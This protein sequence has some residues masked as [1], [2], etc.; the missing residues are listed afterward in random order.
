MDVD[1]MIKMVYKDCLC[2]VVKCGW[3]EARWG[4]MD[5]RVRKFYVKFLCV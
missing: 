2:L 4:G 1:I 5:E 3:M